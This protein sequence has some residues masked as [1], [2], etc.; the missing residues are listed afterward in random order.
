VARVI[1]GLS[2]GHVTD[3]RGHTGCTVIMPERPA[4]GALEIAGRAAAVHGLEFLDPRHLAPTVDAVVLAGG[5]AYG[6]EAIWGVMQWLEERGRGFPVSRTVVP[7][8]AGAI[9]FDLSVGDHRARPDRA[10]G[11]AAAAAAGAG[12]VAEGS[13]GAGTGASVG[14]LYGIERAMRGGLGVARVDRDGI[15]TAALMVVNAAGDVRDP[16]TGRL[17]AG[18]RDAP[19][20]RQLVDT[21][22]ALAAGVSPPRFRPAHTTIGVVATTAALSK[23]EAARVA[24]LGLAGFGRALSP[25]HLDTDGDCLFCLS[26]G[27]EPADVAGVGAAAA[28]AVATAI[29]RGV[30]SA[31]PLP[32]LP[33]AR[34]L[35]R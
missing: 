1:P 33:T 24:R 14:K 5:S 19:D 22:A 10:M 21:A 30:L 27:E 12:P 4:A 26:I 34:D 35:S 17:L 25:P 2:V 16:A 29:A 32:G 20:G 9:I 8:V 3:N 7:H 6:L 11:H 15:T 18:A 13:V 28:E 23:A 31:T